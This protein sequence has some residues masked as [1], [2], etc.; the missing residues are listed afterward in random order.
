MMEQVVSP[1]IPRTQSLFYCCIMIELLNGNQKAFFQV[2]GSESITVLTINL[3]GF[4]KFMFF[5][6]LLSLS[7]EYLGKHKTMR[8]KK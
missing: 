2:V 7:P 4:F 3:H 6:S 1:F 5:V 8:V